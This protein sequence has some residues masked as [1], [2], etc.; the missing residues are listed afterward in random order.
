M[1]DPVDSNSSGNKDKRED[2]SQILRM[3]ERLAGSLRGGRFWMRIGNAASDGLGPFVAVMFLLAIATVAVHMARR[4]AVDRTKELHALLTAQEEPYRPEQHPTIA[5]AV[6]GTTSYSVCKEPVFKL[7]QEVHAVFQAHYGGNDVNPADYPALHDAAPTD[8]WARRVAAKYD[9]IP[10]GKSR[11]G[12]IEY[13]DTSTTSSLRIPTGLSWFIGTKTPERSLDLVAERSAQL[14]SFIELVTPSAHS[15]F[16]ALYFISMEGVLRRI[17]HIDIPLPP[18]RVFNGTGY[19]YGALKGTRP[20]CKETNSYGYETLP[21]L[22][23]TGGG[24][25]VT[26]CY[27]VQEGATIEG[28]FCADV[29]VPE[30]KVQAQLA[31]RKPLFDLALAMVD[32]NGK[33]VVDRKLICGL[34]EIRCLPALEVERY[35]R[36]EIESAIDEWSESIEHAVPAGAAEVKTLKNGIYAAVIAERRRPNKTNQ[37][38]IVF[39]RPGSPPQR[40]FWPVA[41]AILSVLAGG[42]VAAYYRA[43]RDRRQEAAFARGLQVGVIRVSSSKEEKYKDAIIG[44]NDRAEEVLNRMLP[45]F[46]LAGARSSGPLVKFSELLDNANRLLVRKDGQWSNLE[47]DDLAPLRE[48]GVWSEYYAKLKDQR[49]PEQERWIRVLGSPLR[50]PDHSFETFG[51]VETVE[52]GL[53]GVLEEELARR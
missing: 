37:Y 48:R 47:Y 51:V 10:E 16:V 31:A 39:L 19:M 43:R 24:V 25:V 14:E 2:G 13:A 12:Q 36:R 3:L 49:L 27:P 44:A 46:G 11:D 18:E 29:A 21:Y 26:L 32:V 15:S 30:D 40:A 53:A 35:S 52:K 34:D 23:L 5:A 20:A 1:S 7:I 22:D 8:T 9:M 45:R 50:Q 41:I 38:D 28:V 6:F 33:G 4:P 42:F 17:P